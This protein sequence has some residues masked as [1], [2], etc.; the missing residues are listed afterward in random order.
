VIDLSADSETPGFDEAAALR[1]AGITYRNLPIHGARD[2]DASNVARF[3]QLLADA[4]DKLTLVHCASS[5]RV[6]AMMALR[7]AT[8]GGQPAEAA[9][10]EGRRWGLKSL[11]PAVR[12]R[13]QQLPNTR[14]PA[15]RH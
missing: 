5:N 9:V 1:K 10:A 11:E 12:E 8:F 14:S 13:L 15:P 2:L 4:G 6:G 7:A 3:N